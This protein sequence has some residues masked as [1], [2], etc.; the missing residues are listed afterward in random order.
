[1]PNSSANALRP[2]FLDREVNLD[3]EQLPVEYVVQ[4]FA[5]KGLLTVLTAQTTAGKTQLA[6]QLGDA[7]GGGGGD[8][9]GLRCRSG[10]VLYLDA[11]NGPPIIQ[12]RQRAAALNPS[13]IRYLNM[14]GARLDRAQDH[15]VLAET[16]RQADAD[17]VVLDSLRRL[18]GSAKE[19]SAD[20][21]APLIGGLAN[22][23]RETGAAVVLI[24]HRSTKS[25]AAISRGS[26]AIEDQADILFTLDK[27][28]AF[29]RLEC[30]KMRV[31]AEPAPIDLRLGTAPLRLAL[32]ADS[33]SGQL[34][35]LNVGD[36]WSLAKIGEAVGLD[37]KRPADK[38]RLQRALQ[39]CEWVSVRHGVY[40]PGD[41]PLPTP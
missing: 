1:M 3:A 10:R 25:G 14:A 16:V 7:V 33:I 19:D 30:R 5:A 17:L 28:A 12:D 11:E 22:V 39:S 36:G 35:G 34:D 15:A 40:A 20:D 26:S 23:A 41:V 24:H 8:V 31:A 21:M 6:L 2:S 38:K 13:L 32:V 29:R 4:G 37:V 27:R 9:C 18:S